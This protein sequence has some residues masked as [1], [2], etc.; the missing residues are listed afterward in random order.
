MKN[1]IILSVFSFF[2]SLPFFLPL[3][4]AE[5][6][7]DQPVNL[8]GFWAQ[9]GNIFGMGFPGTTWQILITFI[10]V[11]AIFLFAF[12]DIF[13]DFTMFSSLTCWVIAI[14]LAIIGALTRGTLA[15]ARWLLVI[16]AWAGTFAIAIAVISAFV[17][18]AL[19]HL[20]FGGAAN[21]LHR[22]QRWMNR[23][24][25]A[26]NIRDGVVAINAA[27]QQG[28]QNTSG[29]QGLGIWMEHGINKTIK[30][31]FLLLAYK[32]K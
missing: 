25:I 6:P 23:K 21:W 32:K 12:H 24:N 3:I 30:K 26:D 29:A 10:I 18:F 14:G 28:R 31:L 1:K 4:R 27:G 17:A 5:I 8:T 22:R 7:L 20:A 16:S 15:T 2:I 19:M 11:F 13:S 9:L